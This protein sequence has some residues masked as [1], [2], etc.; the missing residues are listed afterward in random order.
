MRVLFRNWVAVLIVGVLSL[1]F[2]S[3]VANAS[4]DASD[5]A[6]ATF[7][8][9]VDPAPTTD[10][11]DAPPSG[12]SSADDGDPIDIEAIIEHIRNFL[13]LFDWD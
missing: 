3:T 7:G 9:R 5:A 12:G 1:S 8:D 11:G 13:D 10:T 6:P 2:L 4:R